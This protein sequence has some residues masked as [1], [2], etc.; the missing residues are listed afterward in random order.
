MKLLTLLKKIPKVL[1][2]K[3]RLI[4]HFYLFKIAK[5]WVILN[6][7]NYRIRPALWRKCGCTVGKNVSMGYDIYFDVH[8]ADLITIE[9]DVWI[10][11]RSLI[12]CHKRILTDYRKGDRYNDLLYKKSPVILKKGCVVGINVTILPGVTVGEGA[13]V[14]VGSLVTK[15]VPAWTIVTGSPA[16]VV[17][18]LEERE[19]E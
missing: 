6:R 12:F 18:V 15:D 1:V 11:S 14:G 9:D 5:N 3:T 8:N 4:Y 13:I 16:K 17:K 7:I 10:G 2:L 19:R